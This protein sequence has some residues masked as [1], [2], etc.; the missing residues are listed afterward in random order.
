[1]SERTFAGLTL[2]ELAVAGAEAGRRA[3]EEAHAAGV[4]T[5]GMVK[6]PMAD[7]QEAELMCW[8]HPDGTIEVRDE[9]L[10]FAIDPEDLTT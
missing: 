5:V 2:D 3:V 10:R 7:G 8:T 1:M 4:A 6:L 9:R